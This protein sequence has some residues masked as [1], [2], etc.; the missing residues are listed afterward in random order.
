MI[1]DLVRVL[2]CAGLLFTVHG[3][4]G[5]R[6]MLV[7]VYGSDE[8]AVVAV[9]CAAVGYGPYVLVP[10][11]YLHGL[12]ASQLPVEFSSP[13]PVREQGDRWVYVHLE[14][15]TPGPGGEHVL[16]RSHTY[17]VRVK[18]M[19]RILDVANKEIYWIGKE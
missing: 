9:P 5:S 13:L 12:Q 14:L 10:S 17:A 16:A 1:A 7:D 8:P 18:D 11:G 19:E 15:R 3:C 4:G 2:I 6:Y